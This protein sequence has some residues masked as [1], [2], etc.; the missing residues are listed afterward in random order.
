MYEES[1]GEINSEEQLDEWRGVGGKGG[2]LSW[3]SSLGDCVKGK[4]V[5]TKVVKR[6]MEKKR[7]IQELL[8]KKRHERKGKRGLRILQ[9]RDQLLLRLKNLGQLTFQ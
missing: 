6:E 2:K 3:K 5:W 8:K 9:P 7:H 1:F 4:K